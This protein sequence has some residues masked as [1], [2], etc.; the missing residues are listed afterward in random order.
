MSRLSLDCVSF[1]GSGLLRPE[2]V[3]THRSGLLFTADWTKRGGVSIVDPASGSVSR[4]LSN[5][6]EVKPNGILLED[7]GTFLLTHLGADDGGV[8]RL[9]PTGTIEPVL[10]EVGGA[11][12]PPSNFAVKD[13]M[14]RL[15]VTISTRKI[16]RHAAAHAD[17]RDGFIVMKPPVGRAL[18]VADGLGYTNEALF[19]PDGRTLY[20]NET[21]SRETSAFPVHADGSLGKREVVARYGHGIYPDG[22]ALDVTGHLW[23]TS[24]ISNTVL[25]VAPDG[26]QE[27]ILDDR[28]AAFVD[29]VEE[30]YHAHTLDRVLLDRPHLGPLKN[31]SSLAFGGPNLSTAYL[32]CLLGDSIAQFASPVAGHTPPHYDADIAPLAE[33]GRLPHRT[34]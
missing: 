15:Y 13:D 12:L 20:V 28:D 2:C 18:I 10:T 7:N 1:T 21:F 14:G 4:L 29:A 30:H 33:A 22:L 9:H 19:S 17:A 5:R 11:P 24:I 6:A 34:G 31:V 32:G 25:R 16:P 27:T 26:T 8:F 23:I 3:L